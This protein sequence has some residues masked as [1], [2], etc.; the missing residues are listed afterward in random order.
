M[1]LLNQ[2]NKQV[3]IGFS[4]FLCYFSKKTESEDGATTF[5]KL[6]YA[7]KNRCI[8]HQLAED[9]KLC[10]MQELMGRNY[11]LNINQ[12]D[13]ENSTALVIA[14]KNK[15]VDFAK[16]LI[17]NHSDKIDILVKSRKLGNAI[18]LA[19]R[20]QEFDIID[21]ILN[22]KQIQKHDSYILN[23]IIPNFEKNPTENAK[24][25]VKLI[26]E[27]GMNP[28]HLRQ[29]FLSKELAAEALAL[30][31]PDKILDISPISLAC[32]KYQ[33]NAFNFIV[34]FNSTIREIKYL[35]KKVQKQKKN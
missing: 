33:N 31:L 14:L 30:D 15:F 28:N 21:Q 9:N 27:K 13:D 16:F 2:K 10:L 20:S 19:M 23:Y 22:H 26:L 1:L 24:Y 8:L 6:L 3:S 34:K 32:M 12:P 25:I 29:K 7:P 5:R 4:D 17:K 18:N 11:D 35:D